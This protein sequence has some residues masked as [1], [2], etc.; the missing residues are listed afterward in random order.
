MIILWCL[1][2]DQIYRLE[3]QKRIKTLEP[4]NH[5]RR[6]LFDAQDTIDVQRDDLI[7][8][9]DGQMRQWTTITPMFAVR[10]ELR[11]G[12]DVCNFVPLIPQRV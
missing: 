4:R 10:W 3:G 1:Q 9:I 12:H 7:A 11:R 8:K 6:E 2:I 5:K